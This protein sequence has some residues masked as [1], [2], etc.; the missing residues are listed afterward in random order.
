MKKNLLILLLLSVVAGLVFFEIN[1]KPSSDSEE[2]ASSASYSNEERPDVT[3]SKEEKE[4]NERSFE[5][6]RK[7]KTLLKA[8]SEYSSYA[9][10]QI[11]GTWDQIRF[12]APDK[13][14]YGFRVDGSVYDQ[15]HDVIYAISYAGH[16][17]KINREAG[18]YTKTSW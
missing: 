17:W 12:L 4:V 18:D 8:G 11:Q 9:E 14:S 2:N 15:E 3:M 16:I 7:N 5:R 13:Q 1:Q 6:Q 10:G